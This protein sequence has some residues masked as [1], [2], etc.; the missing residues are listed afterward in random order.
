MF[1]DLQGKDTTTVF[2]GE[3]VMYHIHEGVAGKS[4]SGKVTVD[5][6]KLQP[7]SR[8]GGNTCA[9]P[10]LVSYPPIV[11]SFPIVSQLPF[12]S[13]PPLVSYLPTVSDLPIV[14]R[15]HVRPACAC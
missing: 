4:P 13:Y 2:L 5:A 14:G 6:A 10:S 7:V 11:S 12:V 3:V 9:L 15:L 8:L 1:A